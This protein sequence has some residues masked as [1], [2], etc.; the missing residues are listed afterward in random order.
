[1]AQ[2]EDG[3][4][5]RSHSAKN[6]NQHA[7]FLGQDGENSPAHKDVIN[8]FRTLPIWLDLP[9]LR[10]VNARWHDASREALVPFLDEAGR[11]DLVASA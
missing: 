6:A 8:W 10:V 1:M 5:L 9:G 7:K 4:F 11:L 3:E 2:N